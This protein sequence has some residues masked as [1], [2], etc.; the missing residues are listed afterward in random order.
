MLDDTCYF[1][2]FD[3]ISE[4]LIT[5]AVLN[6]TFTIDLLRAITFIDAKRPYTKDIL[7]RIDLLKIASH[8]GFKKTCEILTILPDNLSQNLTKKKW[9]DFLEKYSEKQEEQHQYALFEQFS[10]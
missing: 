1:L 9:N 7:M 3:D 2:G 8:L 6:S 5:F 4:T 10:L